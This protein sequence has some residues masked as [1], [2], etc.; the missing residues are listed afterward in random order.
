[1]KLSGKNILVTG[2]A[3]R[4]GRTIALTLAAQGADILIHYHGSQ[5]EAQSLKMEI[6][7]LG[8]RAFLCRFDFGKSQVGLQK[9][10]SQF[11]KKLPAPV[12]MLVNNAAIYY[13]TP[14]GKIT[15]QAWDDFLT[16]NLKSPFF[17]TQEIG[18]QMVKRRRG[19]IVNLVDIA[20]EN[21]FQNYL[22]YSISKAGLIAATKGLAKELAPY[23]QVNGVAP[24]PILEP[25]QGLSSG[26]RKKIAG[27][28]L[29]KRFG[30]AQD[31]AD[32]VQF[33][34][35]ADYVTGQVLAVDGG[36]S[37]S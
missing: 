7:S 3:K 2:A 30:R 26:A 12:D 8:S 33:F 5:K 15:D 17:L 24:G 20:G 27:A 29:L 34:L 21:P 10:T 9:K 28:T 19:K 6:E 4:I 1:M 14:F 31:I 11:V 35:E 23:V 36:K 25:V 13:S 37:L 16:V 18:A 32:A 22:P